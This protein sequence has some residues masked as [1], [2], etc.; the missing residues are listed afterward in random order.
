VRRPHPR[1]RARVGLRCGHLSPCAW[2]LSDAAWPFKGDFLF[3]FICLPVRGVPRCAHLPV[4]LVRSYA[5]ADLRNSSVR[6]MDK[7]LRLVLQVREFASPLKP[8]R[9]RGCLLFLPGCA[10]GTHVAARQ[11]PPLAVLYFR[12]LNTD[13]SAL[14]AAAASNSAAPP[15]SDPPSHFMT[16]VH[17]AAGGSALSAVCTFR[18]KQLRDS[19]R[20]RGG[21]ERGSGPGR[22]GRTSGMVWWGASGKGKH[23]RA[24]LGDS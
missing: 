2:R 12:Q 21:M 22:A 15:S 11:V 1:T 19:A 3:R 17:S 13:G 4:G 5:R 9:R 23:R 20:G 14:A 16:A 6:N 10:D 7:M 24:R 8:P 18:G